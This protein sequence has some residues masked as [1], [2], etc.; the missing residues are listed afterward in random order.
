MTEHDS[1]LKQKGM[2]TNV[3]K[4]EMIYFGRKA[5]EDLSPIIVKGDV[6]TLKNSIKVLGVHFQTD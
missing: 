1:L 2:V 4:T 6:V 5:I 3:A